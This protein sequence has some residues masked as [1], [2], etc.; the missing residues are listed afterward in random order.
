MWLKWRK[1]RDRSALERDRHTLAVQLYYLKLL[2]LGMK[3]WKM[4]IEAI[5][6]QTRR[7]GIRVT[8]PTVDVKCSCRVSVCI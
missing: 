7:K 5:K 2:A 6:E 1:A 4:Y 3:G 8:I